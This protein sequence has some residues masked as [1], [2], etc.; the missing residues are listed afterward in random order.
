M[1]KIAL[2][3]SAILAFTLSACASLGFSSNRTLPIQTQIL[4]GIFRMEGAPNAITAQQAAELLPLWQAHKDLT[5]SGSAAQEE[6]DALNN[7]IQSAMTPEQ[8]QAIQDMQLTRAIC[9]R[10]CR[11]LALL[12]E[13][14]ALAELR[15]RAA[16]AVDSA[17]ADSPAAAVDSPVA[18]V[19]ADKV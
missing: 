13:E 3:I 12:Q 8:M 10:S 18:A 2:V 4:I 11:N 16:G 7:Q 1:K 5:T 9:P 14:A 15:Q 19:A 6:I 17:A